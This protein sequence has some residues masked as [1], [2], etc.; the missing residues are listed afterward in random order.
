M[1]RPTMVH[2]LAANLEAVAFAEHVKPPG[3]AVAV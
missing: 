1:T 2:V 3:F